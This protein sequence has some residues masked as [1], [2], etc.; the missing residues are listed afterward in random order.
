MLL[1]VCQRVLFRRR[2]ERQHFGAEARRIVRGSQADQVGFAGVGKFG[3][4]L[5]GGEKLLALFDQLDERIRWQNVGVERHFPGQRSVGDFLR[6]QRAHRAVAVKGAVRGVRLDV[7]Q[8]NQRG[9]D[10][11]V[12]RGGHLHEPLA[13]NFAPVRGGTFHPDPKT[14]CSYCH[15]PGSVVKNRF[16]ALCLRREG[17]RNNAGPLCGKPHNEGRRKRDRRGRILGP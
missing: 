2:A 7:L 3:A 5:H 4:D 15:E 16:E 6:N 14:L 12:V 1:A 9:V 8:I 11:R 13:G 17:Y 10:L